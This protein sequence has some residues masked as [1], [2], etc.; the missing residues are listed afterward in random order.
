MGVSHMTDPPPPPPF[1]NSKG[2]STYSLAQAGDQSHDPL[3]VV[4]LAHGRILGPR[5]GREV[6]RSEQLISDLL[7]MLL[8]DLAQ[9]RY[10]F[11]FC[12][13]IAT[14]HTS[15]C[16]SSSLF[17][18]FCPPLCSESLEVRF[19]RLHIDFIPTFSVAKIASKLQP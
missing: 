2:L 6:V 3:V 4:Q 11:F 8:Q 19:M 18:L 5:P 13:R 15:R 17:F 9:C 7:V 10:Y 1:V 12:S 16:G 14:E